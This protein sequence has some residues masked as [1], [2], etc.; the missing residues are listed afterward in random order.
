MKT[1]LRVMLM[2]LMILGVV[3][4]SN[5]TQTAEKD[6]NDES[7]TSDAVLQDNKGEPAN[8]TPEDESMESTSDKTES[9]EEPEVDENPL[10][11]KYENRQWAAE[12]EGI[13][14]KMTVDF[15]NE[16]GRYLQLACYRRKYRKSVRRYKRYSLYNRYGES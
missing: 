9:T 6:T 5:D 15:T 10:Q 7:E 4:C 13:T 11:E 8:E 1:L 16:K 3:A 2:G 12:Q 14:Y